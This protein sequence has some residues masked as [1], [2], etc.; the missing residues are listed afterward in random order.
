[1]RIDI[2]KAIEKREIKTIENWL[3]NA[4]KEEINE[5]N[6]KQQNMLYIAAWEGNLRI[7]K[8]F[9]KKGAEFCISQSGQHVLHRAA[10]N[11][12]GLEILRYL[13]EEEG[14][15]YLQQ[16][17]QQLGYK[18]IEE[19]VNAEDAIGLTPMLMAMQ[20]V[21]S[22]QDHPHIVKE[23]NALPVIQ[24][25]LNNGAKILPAKDGRNVILIAAQCNQLDLLEF[26]LQGKGKQALLK[27][28]E[29]GYDAINAVTEDDSLTPLLVA[30]IRG[31]FT[32]AKLLLLNGA[33]CTENQEGELPSQILLKDLKKNP[34]FPQLYT[35]YLSGLKQSSEAFQQIIAP[36]GFFELFHL[37]KEVESGK[38][39]IETKTETTGTLLKS[40]MATSVENTDIFTALEAKNINLCKQILEKDTAAAKQVRKKYR[41]TA[42]HLAAIE[43]TVDIV[44]LL[45]AKGADVEALD[46]AKCNPLHEAAG[47]NH[48]AVVEVLV[49]KIKNINAQ[50]TLGLTALHHAALKGADSQVIEILIKHGADSSLRGMKNRSL[51]VLH[52]A[53]MSENLA[54]FKYLMPK[55][56]INEL[57]GCNRTPLMIAIEGG[58]LNII[59]FLLTQNVDKNIKDKWG[60]TLED[61]VNLS[62]VIVR[63]AVKNLMANDLTK[64]LE[65][66][67]AES[68]TTTFN[69]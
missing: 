18:T 67:P 66:V 68:L 11:D 57:D 20:R 23:T 4:K 7:F 52:C 35:T 1:M 27:A 37:L 6:N 22:H 59:A 5:L 21:I 50:D 41:Q 53:A 24:L 47:H 63:D 62:P 16:A 48:F 46:I 56:D 12:R 54:T 25:L 31:N 36:R 60:R 40:L 9:L 8:L 58:H 32:A 10:I 26:F 2:L 17:L 19:A 3:K 34:K 42:L 38:K 44:K 15:E 64:K 45:M 30:I 14:K 61:Y 43:G 51:S 65:E 13:L 49:G 29:D 55:F 33:R 69:K 28:K 39:I